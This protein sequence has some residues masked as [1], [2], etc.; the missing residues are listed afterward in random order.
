MKANKM[1]E[2]IYVHKCQAWWEYM[3]NE[4]NITKNETEYVRTD[5]FIKKAEEYLKTQFINDVSVLA[6]GVVNINFSTA[7]KNFVKYMKGE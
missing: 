6:G 1:P 2:K 3:V 5:I 7:I 4:H